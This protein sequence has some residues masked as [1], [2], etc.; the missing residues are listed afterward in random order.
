MRCMCQ[1]AHV[2]V[3]RR[4]LGVRTEKVNVAESLGIANCVVKP[5]TYLA[6]PPR[7]W[8][9]TLPS[10][11]TRRTGLQTNDPECTPPAPTESL[12]V[13]FRIRGARVST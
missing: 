11:P 9:K 13:S 8:F 12:R 7:G 1:S 10:I 4:A 3:E 5:S 6:T 2:I